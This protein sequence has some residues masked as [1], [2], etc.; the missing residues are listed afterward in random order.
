MSDF[1]P[2]TPIKEICPEEFRDKL[3]EIGLIS[4]PIED[5][6]EESFLDKI[7]YSYLLEY[8]AGDEYV[9][10]IRL[11]ILDEIDINIPGLDGFKL[12][13]RAGETQGII[14]IP[15]RFNLKMEL[16]LE[17]G[18]FS[19]GEDLG[20]EILI[21]DLTA[22]LRF[23]KTILKP[24]QPG[25][26]EIIQDQF[27]ELT[28]SGFFKIGWANSAFIFE[29][30]SSGGIDL[31]RSLIGDT[32]IIISAIGLN[33][34][35]SGEN[36]GVSFQEAT[37]ELP[38][39]IQ[40]IPDLTI[41]NCNIN[42]NG[43]SGSLSAIWNPAIDGDLLGFKI[44]LE[45]IGLTFQS[46]KLTDSLIRGT[47]VIPFFHS[48]DDPADPVEF[49]ASIGDKGQFML[50]LAASENMDSIAHV[51]INDDIN[52][53]IRKLQLERTPNSDSYL[54]M[55]NRLTVLAT[56]PEPVIL[57]IED[58]KIY[59]S[60]RV[61]FK[62]G[63]FD[64]K[65]LLTIERGGFRIGISSIGLGLDTSEGGKN[66][67]GF[68]GGLKFA[69]NLS[70][71]VYGAQ[72]TWYKNNG[73]DIVS[74]F[75]IQGA[76]I[77]FT[78]PEL[79][80]FGAKLVF[81]KREDPFP[82]GIP[83]KDDKIS[84]LLGSLKLSL[85]PF[86]LGIDGQFIIGK[87]YNPHYVFWMAVLDTV[88]PTGIPLGPTGLGVYLFQGL[89]AVNMRPDKAPE[90]HWYRD[91]YKKPQ[92]GATDIMKWIPEPDS[93]AV[94]IGTIIG[95]QQDD[96]FAFSSKAVL[97]VSLFG[98]QIILGG[99][100]NLLKNRE[101]LLDPSKDPLFRFMLVYDNTDRSFLFAL[102]V[103]YVRK[104]ILT[105]AG[106]A[107]VYFS[108]NPKGWH[109]YLGEKPPYKRIRAEVLKLFKANTYFMIDSKSV[110]FGFFIGYKPDP[111]KFGPV[112]IKLQAYIEAHAFISWDPSLYSGSLE[113]AGELAIS[114]FSIDLG[115]SLHA[116][117]EAA[118]P[119]P[120]MIGLELEIKINLPWPLPDPEVVIKL[121]YEQKIPP[122]IRDPFVEVQFDDHYALGRTN[123]YPLFSSLD[124]FHGSEIEAN[125]NGGNLPLVPMDGTLCIIFNRIMGNESNNDLL[126]PTQSCKTIV[127]KD[128]VR[129][130]FSH[131][132]SYFEIGKV[133]T[134]IE[135]GEM[136]EDNVIPIND[137]RCTWAIEEIAD[138]EGIQ[139]SILQLNTNN[140][141]HV[142][143]MIENTRWS[144]I[145]AWLY[146]PYLCPD[147]IDEKDI[148]TCW[149]VSKEFGQG[150]IIDDY[151][152]NGFTIQVKDVAYTGLDYLPNN[153]INELHEALGEDFSGII[154]AYDTCMEIIFDR[155]TKLFIIEGA[156]S[157]DLLIKIYSG[158]DELKKIQRQSDQITRFEIKSKDYISEKH[159]KITKVLIKGSQLYIKKICFISEKDSENLTFASDQ[160]EFMRT[161]RE[162]WETEALLFDPNTIYKVSFK[163][164]VRRSEIG[165][166]NN[167]DEKPFPE[168]NNCVFYFKTGGSPTDLTPYIKQTIP[169]KNSKLFFRQY[170]IDVLF[171]VNHIPQMYLM[172]RNHPLF[173]HITSSGGYPICDPNG[174][175]ICDET[176]QPLLKLPFNPVENTYCLNESETRFFNVSSCDGTTRRTA[177]SSSR[178]IRFNP[179]EDQEYLLEP[180]S[181]YICFLGSDGHTETL[182]DG[183]EK[184]RKLY[185]FSFTTSKF[186]NFRNLIES[187]A[188][189]GIHNLL[190][191]RDYDLSPIQKILSSNERKEIKTI[192]NSY[193]WSVE[194]GEDLFR[195]NYD[196]EKEHKDHQRL[197]DILSIFPY[198]SPSSSEVFE[199]KDSSEQF[200]YLLQ[201]PEPIDW[202]RVQFS[203]G[204]TRV[205]I[206]NNVEVVQS[207]EIN[208]KL[209]R[210]YDGTAAF[211]KFKPGIKIKYEK[212][213]I[214]D[215]LDMTFFERYKYLRKPITI[216]P[217][218]S[219]QIESIVSKKAGKLF[220]ANEAVKP[221]VFSIQHVKDIELKSEIDITGN[222]RGIFFTFISIIPAVIKLV[223]AWVGLLVERLFGRWYIRKVQTEIDDLKVR[224][225]LE[226]QLKYTKDFSERD[227]WPEFER[228]L[229]IIAQQGVSEKF[230]DG[231]LS[232]V[233]DNSKNIT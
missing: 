10:D 69:G 194:M 117:I 34:I 121:L 173:L 198:Q 17:S 74:Q 103:S 188:E 84:G 20:I 193:E 120:W 99:K 204:L 132:I 175:I 108:D 231:I 181:R 78:I 113:A 14:I 136:I 30:S 38:P 142:D 200:G 12:I 171:F 29:F 53:G 176:G 119:K 166:G 148:K 79:F 190:D 230:E 212:V 195:E 45:Q 224:L 158:T 125:E 233:F 186:R 218:I 146:N 143:R 59:S 167:S 95:T 127:G 112:R 80:S 28:I 102:E 155:E 81:F 33:V 140:P 122:P 54:L 161:L 228:E 131:L 7:Y 196:R 101:E 201:F 211:L 88:L 96:G 37:L 48:S 86:N 22:S 32:G 126:A 116:L 213:W 75:N 1:L 225:S 76:E 159:P 162:N 178:T 185:E 100:I 35:L 39:D 70:A 123:T 27:S 203:G 97:V 152:G 11:I 90:E 87:N 104:K 51:D 151:E 71:E 6:G 93:F 72:Y 65:D 141:F 9:L 133:E 177:V 197:R 129:Y 19:F 92:I 46:N 89:I 144:E 153:I 206:I 118:G 91:W 137:L 26:R 25:S 216:N 150:F 182:E 114:V 68:T 221:D 124:D 15:I 106:L 145:D 226:L 57:D 164:K 223:V 64:V 199:L 63:W 139:K 227:N 191:L 5:N 13:L 94:G 172:D 8:R 77:G 66:F 107:E 169:A 217:P 41:S 135:E 67:I 130:E 165:S 24:V 109:I 202:N 31:S 2:I 85:I 115:L 219:V 232:F 208:F 98:P 229:P 138:E 62:G 40:G 180:E 42:T 192:Y 55:T 154:T 56:Q 58:L 47:L 189:K 170:C 83:E 210:N 205:E 156:S 209:I 4:E 157:D 220:D 43:F 174:D 163:A 52:L 149:E 110:A 207:P 21:S 82:Y 222:K 187:G 18:N 111:M 23:P 128:G 16:E 184:L 147:Q 49:S 134:H 214:Q 44:G 160:K 36:A 73:G 179:G 105:L 168:N 60:G 50:S 215:Y 3:Y 183:T 61:E